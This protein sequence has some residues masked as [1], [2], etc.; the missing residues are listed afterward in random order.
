M[1][2][3]GVSRGL[4]VV[5]SDQPTL[6]DQRGARYGSGHA[7][8]CLTERGR[9]AHGFGGPGRV[10]CRRAMRPSVLSHCR[11]SDGISVSAGGVR[12]S[13]GRGVAW[14]KARGPMGRSLDC[15]RLASR[16]TPAAPP[17]PLARRSLSPDLQQA[18]RGHR[19]TRRARVAARHGPGSEG[20]ALGGRSLLA[21]R[22]PTC[23]AAP[24]H[25]PQRVRGPLRGSSRACLTRVKCSARLSA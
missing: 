24:R 20:T 23:L 21:R 15:V 11:A 8:A 17:R 2:L 25:S 16:G 22:S 3:R 18:T 14:R 6:V 9:R 13:R 12:R 7:E 5:V 10:A 19:C 1:N 4:V